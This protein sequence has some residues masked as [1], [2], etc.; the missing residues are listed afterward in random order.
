MIIQ[1]AGA[2][3]T[4]AQYSAGSAEILP[5]WTGV[6]DGCGLSI[7]LNDACLL[8]LLIGKSLHL[9]TGCA[10]DLASKLLTDLR[11]YQVSKEKL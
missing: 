5:A 10:A 7:Q 9:H 4:Y 8:R 2:G 1:P 11:D 3:A 6:C